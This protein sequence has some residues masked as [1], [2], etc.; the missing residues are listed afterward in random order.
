M[1]RAG[2]PSLV[3]EAIQRR[4]Q[5]RLTQKDL[6]IIAKVNKPT[7]VKFEK[8]NGNITLDAMFA[9]SRALGLLKPDY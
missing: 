8:Q 9:I 6:A 7:V 3:S 2:W 1:L 5:Q 4:K